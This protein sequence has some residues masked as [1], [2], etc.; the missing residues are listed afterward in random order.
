MPSVIK[1][2]YKSFRRAI[3]S[4]RPGMLS[5]DV[6]FLH[7]NARSHMANAVKTTLQQFRWETLE[8]QPYSPDLSPCNF[9]FLHLQNKLFV[10]IDSQRMTKCVT[11]SRTGSNSRLLASSKME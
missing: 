11:V 9:I 3:K 2:H 1:P 10:G 4:K 7:D 5:S 6:I 8:Y